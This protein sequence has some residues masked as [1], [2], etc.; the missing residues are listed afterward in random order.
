[1]RTGKLQLQQRLTEV[2][3]EIAA[4]EADSQAQHYPRAQAL[5]AALH[6]MSDR[7]RDDLLAEYADW[8]R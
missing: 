2:E 3:R 5:G 6:R 8:W 7:L 4:I 1:M